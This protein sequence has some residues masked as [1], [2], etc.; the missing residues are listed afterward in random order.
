MALSSSCPHL[1]EAL[2]G[3]AGS[4]WRFKKTRNWACVHS[5]ARPL[6]MQRFTCKISFHGTKRTEGSVGTTFRW[7]IGDL[8]AMEQPE[9]STANWLFMKNSRKIPFP[10]S[11]YSSTRDLKCLW[12]FISHSRGG[13]LPLQHGPF[14]QDVVHGLTHL[15]REPGRGPVRGTPNFEDKRKYAQ[16]LLPPGT[17]ARLGM[18]IKETSPRGLL[19]PRFLGVFSRTVVSLCA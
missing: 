6:Y 2:G 11:E 14:T 15:P 8:R 17:W 7:Q 13:G 16:K 5:R 19:V 10:T 4:T 18:S 1:S 9:L 12:H 3:W